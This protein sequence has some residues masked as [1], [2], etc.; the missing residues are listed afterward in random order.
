[1]TTIW[2]GRDNGAVYFVAGEPVARIQ[3]RPHSD[4]YSCLVLC[5]QTMH[6]CFALDY[7]QAQRWVE[8]RVADLGWVSK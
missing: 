2:E 1:M 8:Q 3:R 4:T 6:S 7:A 5:G